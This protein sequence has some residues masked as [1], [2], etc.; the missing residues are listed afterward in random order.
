MSKKGMITALTGAAAFVTFNL[1]MAGKKGNIGPFAFLHSWRPEIDKIK[2]TYKTDRQGEI[3]FYGASNF[4]RWT[5]MEWD[6]REYRVQ[7]HAFGGSTDK[8]L[9]EYANEILYPYQPNIVFFQTG[10]N[11]YVAIKGS[12]EEKIAQCMAYKK[13]MFATFHEHLP[14]AKFVVMSG[15]LLPG[16]KQY[17][18]LTLRI[19]EELKKYCDTLDYMYYVD[20]NAMTYYGGMLD[21]TLFVKDMIHLN[22]EGQLLWCRKYI[23]P[24]IEQLICEYGLES[25]RK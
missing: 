16:R 7:N 8:D 11:D 10:S 18:N 23:R 13:Q 5:E 19:N 17:L 20:A 2:T 3:I 4:A 14:E 25:L 22:H 9:V 6:L 12:D 24:M 15:L 21:R 1:V